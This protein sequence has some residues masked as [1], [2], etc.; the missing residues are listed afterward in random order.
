MSETTETKSAAADPRYQKL[1]ELIRP[2]IV[3]P[4]IHVV[5]E[6]DRCAIFRLA[7]S[8]YGLSLPDKR[9]SDI[10]VEW[11]PGATYAWAAGLMDGWDLVPMV[12]GESW[13]WLYGA[14]RTPWDEA[15]EADY[16]AGRRAGREARREIL[17]EGEPIT[18]RALAEVAGV[19]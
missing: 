16:W 17:G 14:N 15:K 19:E 7:E 4:S 13:N 3:E 9:M 5:R 11:I 8:V 6:G 12:T 2:T 1:M 10:A 18:A